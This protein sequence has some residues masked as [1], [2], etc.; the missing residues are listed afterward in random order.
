MS[1]SHS[2]SQVKIRNIL[3]FVLAYTQLLLSHLIIVALEMV[4]RTAAALNCMLRLLEDIV[5]LDHYRKYYN[6]Q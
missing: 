1:T 2:T 3:L 6:S 4:A 5:T